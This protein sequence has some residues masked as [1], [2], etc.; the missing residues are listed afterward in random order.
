M[1]ATELKAKADAELAKVEAEKARAEA[2]AEAEKAR[3][4]AKADA[5]LARAEAEKARAETRGEADRRILDFL[6]TSGYKG[7]RDL[8]DVVDSELKDKKVEARDV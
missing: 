2:K 8:V 6:T 1:Q 7:L 3:A 5:K 4:E